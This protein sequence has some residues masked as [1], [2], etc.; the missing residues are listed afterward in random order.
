MTEDS[1]MEVEVGIR[2]VMIAGEVVVFCY[3]RWELG[4]FLD[5]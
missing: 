2:V 5:G 1:V 3:V 4:A